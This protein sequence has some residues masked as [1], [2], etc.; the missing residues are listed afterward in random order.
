MSI[1]WLF[2]CFY[3]HKIHC[4]AAPSRVLITITHSASASNIRHELF[5][6]ELWAFSKGGVETGEKMNAVVMEDADE[7]G[8]TR[9]NFVNIGAWCFERNCQRGK[10]MSLVVVH[11]DDDYDW[12]CK[13]FHNSAQRA[14]LMAIFHQMLQPQSLWTITM[15][16]HHHLSS[17]IR[18]HELYY[19]RLAFHPQSHGVGDEHS[20]PSIAFVILNSAHNLYYLT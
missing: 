20:A 3:C 7:C 12:V 5:Q 6:T 14:A 13:Q 16:S 17:F 2:D 19:Q 15:I 10:C 18:L 11:S 9:D 4:I 1:Y 8:V